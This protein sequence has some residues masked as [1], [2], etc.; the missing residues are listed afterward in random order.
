MAV[1]QSIHRDQQVEVVGQRL[2]ILRG[3]RA[4][5]KRLSKPSPAYYREW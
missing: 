3:T 4:L 2:V 1:V 5:K